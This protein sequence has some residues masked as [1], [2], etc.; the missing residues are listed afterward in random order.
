MCRPRLHP[1][2]PRLV[3]RLE[4]SGRSLIYPSSSSSFDGLCPLKTKAAAISAECTSPLAITSKTVRP[5]PLCIIPHP[6]AGSQAE[7]LRRLRLQAAR[8]TWRLIS[9]AMAARVHGVRPY[10]CQFGLTAGYSTPHISMILSWLALSPIPH[11]LI[12]RLLRQKLVH[13][14]LE[15]FVSLIAMC[16]KLPARLR[17]V[18]FL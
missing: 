10:G 14:R 8:S 13:C 3:E 1:L 16:V 7:S 18:H 9:S 15:L 6:V 2:P 11:G 17:C 4:L 5:Q 12:A